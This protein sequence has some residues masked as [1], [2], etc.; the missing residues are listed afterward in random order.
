ME[1][2]FTDWVILEYTK[3]IQEVGSENL[4]LTSL[5]ENTTSKDIPPSLLSLGL[6]WTVK[7]VTQLY[8]DTKEHKFI[9]EKNITE[10]TKNSENEK[11]VSLANL[12]HSICLLDPASEID[13]TPNDSNHFQFFVFG[14]ILGDH[15]PRDRT[16]ELREKYGFSG[17]RLGNL[18]MTTDTAVRVTQLIIEKRLP[19]ERIKFIDYPEIK[20]NKYESTEMPFRYVLAEDNKPIFPNGMLDLIKKDTEKS[21]DEDDLF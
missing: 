2:G 13:L 21:F 5:P 7:E 4:I 20:F 19:F 15:P 10:T 18:Q 6:H 1:S 12:S 9:N 16:G 11:I 8:F 14:G 17:R 3:I